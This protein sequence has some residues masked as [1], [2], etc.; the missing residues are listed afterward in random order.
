M[1]KTEVKPQRRVP[2]PHWFV[3]DVNNLVAESENTF[4]KI[5]SWFFC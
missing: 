1:S 2:E 3:S 5:P 4:W